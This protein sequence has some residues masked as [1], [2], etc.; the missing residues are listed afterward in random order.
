M[1]LMGRKFKSEFVKSTSYVMPLHPMKSENTNYS[2]AVLKTAITVEKKYK[3]DLAV[4]AIDF[5]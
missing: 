3:N 2:P 5:V 1:F 4:P